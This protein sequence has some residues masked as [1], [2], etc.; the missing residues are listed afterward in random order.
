M[1][2]HQAK[3]VKQYGDFSSGITA[4]MQYHQEVKNEIFPDE[5]HTYKKQIMDEVSE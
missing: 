4:L 5:S 2:C 1:K 3:F